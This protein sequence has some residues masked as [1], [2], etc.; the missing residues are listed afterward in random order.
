MREKEVIKAVSQTETIVPEWIENEDK[1]ENEE[2]FGGKSTWGSFGF[3]KTDVNGLE[4]KFDVWNHR[5]RSIIT[6]KCD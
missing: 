5:I 4:K 2:T 3:E 1:K 6:T